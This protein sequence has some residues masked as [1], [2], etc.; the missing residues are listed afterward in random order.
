V[1]AG[2]GL[3]SPLDDLSDLGLPMGNALLLISQ[4]SHLLLQLPVTTAELLIHRAQLKREKE[5]T[6]I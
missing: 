5:T 1:A 2:R 6:K 4:L 3:H